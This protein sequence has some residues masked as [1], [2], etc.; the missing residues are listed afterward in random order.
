MIKLNDLGKT[1]TTNNML[2]VGIEH[3]TVS[4]DIN[5]FV[6]IT[7]ESG[8]GKS[9]LLQ[10]LAGI[11][12][13]SYGR[14]IVNS[15][16]AEYYGED[17]WKRYRRNEVAIIH[18]DFQLI[19]DISVYNN[20]KIA[21]SLNHGDD[22]LKSEEAIS[23]I[24]YQTGLSDLINKKVHSLSGGQKQRVAIARALAKDTSIILADEP[25]G[26]LDSLAA[27]E[28]A[29]L[30]KKI[31]KNKLII[32]VTHNE[33][34]FEDVVTR[35][36]VMKGGTITFD[37]SKQ[38]KSKEK[39][40][41]CKMPEK[42]IKRQNE[43]IALLKSTFFMNKKINASVFITVFSV[44][45]IILLLASV[46]FQYFTQTSEGVMYTPVF[47]GVEKERLIIRNDDGSIFSD[48]Q[49][50]NFRSD[51]RFSYIVE[52]DIVLD[53]MFE[54]EFKY[55][56]GTVRNQYYSNTVESAKVK[57]ESLSWGRLPINDD[58]I[59]IS[60]DGTFQEL[61]E[62]MRD[63]LLSAVYNPLKNIKV[64]IVGG[65][66]D[67]DKH[68]QTIYFTKSA[69]NK[70]AYEF[71]DKYSNLKI[72]NQKAGATTSQQ[73]TSFVNDSAEKGVIYISQNLAQEISLSTK[74]EVK[75]IVT[76]KNSTPFYIKSHDFS[77]IEIISI[78]NNLFPE[79]TLGDDDRVVVFSPYDFS[80]IFSDDTYQISLYMNYPN[81]YKEIIE[82]LEDD[83]LLVFYPSAVNIADT[84]SSDIITQFFIFI[85][86]LALSFVLIR[87]SILTIRKQSKTESNK[88]AIILSIGYDQKSI[89]VT[90]VVKN[91]IRVFLSCVPCVLIYT[92]VNV[93]KKVYSQRLVHT[94]IP[95]E[96]I[97]VWFVALIILT[98]GVAYVIS[99]SKKTIKF[100]G[101][102]SITQMMKVGVDNL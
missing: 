31:S 36:V 2:T 98:V 55:D 63:V 84:D 48:M 78:E 37:S 80:E 29:Q 30:L 86:C 87:L 66:I 9:T 58:E 60:S 90:D 85:I 12:S 100:G 21:Y 43:V 51:K 14:M 54:I 96:N 7:G 61:D 88:Y 26:N 73:I 83:G 38:T 95:L 19:E 53:I 67:N 92:I 69:A 99:F 44:I 77:A 89:I 50:D 57:P 93:L 70:I 74:S 39:V 82:D 4:F 11:E 3:I 68:Q 49:I 33:E 71:S 10:I 64:K 79:Y 45:L 25:T 16:D 65:F 40:S 20:I 94:F 34:Y 101:K 76:I 59:L 1:Y 32:V 15:A 81:N 22:K 27:R 13:Y 62:S 42:T 28:I 97:P 23:E 6:M 46:M 52:N 102:I 18:Q 72:T 56:Y 47:G 17:E 24:I 35:H 91:F 8:S 5:E 75:N 41:C